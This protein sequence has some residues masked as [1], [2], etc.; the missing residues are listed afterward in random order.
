MVVMFVPNS[1][2]FVCFALWL[3]ISTFMEVKEMWVLSLLVLLVSSQAYHCYSLFLMINCET[4]TLSS[5]MDFVVVGN[6][7]SLDYKKWKFAWA[8]GFLFVLKKRLNTL[9]RFCVLESL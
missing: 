5:S 6:W 2:H 8:K 4:L 7:R 3:Q 9:L 1:W